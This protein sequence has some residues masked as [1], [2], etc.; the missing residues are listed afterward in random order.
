MVFI[1]IF[2]LFITVIEIS[3]GATKEKISLSPATWPQEQFQRL[4]TISLRKNPRPKPLAFS[5]V[6]GL[7]AGT[8][9]ALAVHAGTD[10]LRKGGNAMD[11]CIATAM[12]GKE[13][14][15]LKLVILCEF[16]TEVQLVRTKLE[17]RI[18]F[19]H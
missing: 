1:Q 4:E 13:K 5:G 6:E 12:A 9:S 15:L 3:Y 18:Q 17:K 11:A 14:R 8:T 7:V 16:L 2:M 10:A 19:D